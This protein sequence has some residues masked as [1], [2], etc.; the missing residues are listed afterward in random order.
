MKDISLLVAEFEEALQEGHISAE[1]MAH[2][3]SEMSHSLY[4]FH[5]NVE[6]WM[7]I[8]LGDVTA[9]LHNAIKVSK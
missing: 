7:P 3:I 2:I 4:A 1:Q 9:D 6:K 8:D 5:R